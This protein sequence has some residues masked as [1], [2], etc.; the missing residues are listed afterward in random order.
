MN[1]K[2]LWKTSPKLRFAARTVGVAAAG[3]IVQSYRGGFTDWKSFASGLATA[4]IT[5]L[6][7]LI[8]PLE[9]FVGVNK[10]KIEVPSPPAVPEP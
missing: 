8:T 7:G 2:Q 3:Y 9:P 10:A 6:L 4:A 5:A 1:L